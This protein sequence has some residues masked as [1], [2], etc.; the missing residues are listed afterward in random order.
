MCAAAVEALFG[1]DNEMCANFARQLASGA[2]I[3]SEMVP[4]V[5][6][7]IRIVTFSSSCNIDVPVSN[8]LVIYKVVQAFRLNISVLKL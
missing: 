5:D 8:R 1:D 3:S 7:L 6:C 2:N 4:T